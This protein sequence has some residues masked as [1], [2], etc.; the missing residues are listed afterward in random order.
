VCVWQRK[1]FCVRFTCV[2]HVLLAV[3][4]RSHAMTEF[5]QTHS[6]EVATCCKM[7]GAVREFHNSLERGMVTQRFTMNLHPI[8]RGIAR[9]SFWVGIIFYCTIIQSS[10]YIYIYIYIYTSIL[11]TSAAISAQNN[12][13][14]LILG[15]YIYRYTP[16]SLRP[17]PYSRY[18]SRSIWCLF[19]LEFSVYYTVHLRILSTYPRSC[20]VVLTLVRMFCI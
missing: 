10:I 6:A 9:N 16:P 19:V 20:I 14:G 5:C 8:L 2:Y 4:K 7:I 3:A 15:G 18:Y 11:T 12:F 13:Q 1:H 17:C